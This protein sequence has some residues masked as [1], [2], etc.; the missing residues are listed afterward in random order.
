MRAMESLAIPFEQPAHSDRAIHRGEHRF[1]KPA[2]ANCINRFNPS[3]VEMHRKEEIKK[4]S[5]RKKTR[6]KKNKKF[7]AGEKK[8]QSFSPC[9]HSADMTIKHAA[10]SPPT[11]PGSP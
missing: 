6:P 7:F 1:L 8:S 2:Y 4:Q 9:S 11:H 10:N 3:Q 5:K